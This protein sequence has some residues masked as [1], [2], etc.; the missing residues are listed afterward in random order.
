[1]DGQNW[2]LNMLK[3]VGSWVAKGNTDREIR[4]LA[5]NHTLPGYTVEQTWLDVQPMIAGARR[6]NF[7][8]AN[9]NEARDEPVPR[10]ILTLIS[11]VELK[12][13]EYLID[14]VI[15]EKSLIGLI[16]PSGSGKT[17]VALDIA[18]SLAT[19]KDYHGF[20]ASK[21]LVIMSAGEGH[22][23]IPRRAEAWCKHNGSNLHAASFAITDRAVDLFN[24]APL[25]AF[26]NEVEEIAKTR[27]N[28]KL[29]IIDTVAR[30]MAGKDENSAKEMGELVQTADK[31]MH[32]Y[33]CAVMLVHHTG[34]SNQDRARGSTAFRG[35]LNTEIL[36][37]SLGDNDIIVSCDKQKDGPEF[38]TMQ[39]LKVSVDPSIALQQVVMS[40]TKNNLTDS[41]TLAMDA[42]YEATKGNVASAG[43]A[44]DEWRPFFN[45]RH[46]GDNT[47]SKNRAF[48]RARKDLVKRG[49]LKCSDDIYRLGDKAT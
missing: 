7:A 45:E 43:L 48:S 38:D 14:D 1:M 31:L 15:E 21:G 3:L 28:P 40:A 39:F 25:N 18:L 10:K 20:G 17:F 36:V 35:A 37:K 44:L 30:H 42:F 47:N 5:E 13:P 27:G 32:D 22:L 2:H 4:I 46:T 11:D 24:E 6:K 23:G 16:G 41:Q 9:N 19:G 49:L 12:E 33:Q 26:C 29:I 8:P 34:H